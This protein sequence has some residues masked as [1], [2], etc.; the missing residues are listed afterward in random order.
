MCVTGIKVVWLQLQ[1]KKK[2]LHLKC[3]CEAQIELGNSENFRMVLPSKA[4]Y[5][6]LVK[7]HDSVLILS[8]STYKK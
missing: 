7:R 6:I 5:P 4:F 8:Y 1:D 3:I 2:E